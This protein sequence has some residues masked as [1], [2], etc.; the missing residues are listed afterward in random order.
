MFLSKLHMYIIYINIRIHPVKSD[1]KANEAVSGSRAVVVD[2]VDVVVVVTV[3]GGAVVVVVTVVVVSAAVVVVSG[4]VV[5]VT[6]G[7]VVSASN[8]KSNSL[9]EVIFGLAV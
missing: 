9:C 3:V 6:A 7:V 2:V 4:A 8:A 5:V 1:K